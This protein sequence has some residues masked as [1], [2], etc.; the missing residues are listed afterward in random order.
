L[1]VHWAAKIYS[2]AANLSENGQLLEGS[3]AVFLKNVFATTFARQ[4]GAINRAPN[5]VYL[6]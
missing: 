6:A 1:N 2:C 3:Q 5:I 4:R